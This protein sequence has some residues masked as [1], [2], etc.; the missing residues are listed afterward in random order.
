MT[1]PTTTQT[2]PETFLTIPQVAELLN[3][4]EVRV[5]ALVKDSSNPLVEARV[6][7]YVRVPRSSYDAF[8]ASLTAA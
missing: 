4:T 3:L 1:T 6:G 5:R 8:V 2:E 7:R